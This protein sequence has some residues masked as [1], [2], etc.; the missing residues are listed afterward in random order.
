[1]NKVFFTADTHFGQERALT[2]SRRPFKSVKE[3]DEYMMING[4]IL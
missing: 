3:M 2:L 4:M 1:M